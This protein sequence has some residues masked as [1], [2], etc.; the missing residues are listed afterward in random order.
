MK[1]PDIKGDI[2]VNLKIPNHC[3]VLVISKSQRSMTH[4]LHKYPAKY[5]PEYPRWAIKKYTGNKNNIVLDPFC[6][7]GTSNVE[8]K[9][10]GHNSLAIDVDPLARFITKNKTTN[11]NKTKLLSTKEQLYDQLSSIKSSKELPENFDMVKLWFRPKVAKELYGLKRQITQI[12]DSKLRDFFLLCFSSSI[13]KVSNADPKLVLPKISKYMRIAEENGRE[14]NVIE[15]FK[16]ITD[17]STERILEFSNATSAQ[18][19]VKIIGNDSRKMKIDDETITLAVTSPP[20]LNAHDYVRS[21]KLELFWLG[22][23]QYREQLISLDRKYIGTEKFYKD[24]YSVLQST[25]IKELDSKISKIAK[26]DTKRAYVTAKFFID[27]ETHFE[28]VHRVLEKNGHYVMFVGS[29]VIRKI[30]VPTYQYL[31]SLAEQ[32]GLKTELHF[33]SPLIKRMEVQSG[34]K[35]SG[36]FIEEDWILVFRK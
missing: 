11:Q 2:P 28:E 20:Y 25:G 33:S 36:G 15:T 14:I 9:L 10:A 21:H 27:M 18:T 19:K 13:R 34:R 30:I 1:L 5:I 31:I 8:A 24:E 6:G 35:E 22:L 4:A 3:S 26:I 23:A 16:K 12:N 29:N 32:S 17:F 7:S